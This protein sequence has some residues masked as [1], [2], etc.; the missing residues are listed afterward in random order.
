MSAPYREWVTRRG[1]GEGRSISVECALCPPGVPVMQYIYNSLLSHEPAP[2]GRAMEQ[3]TIMAEP[4]A[5]EG[6][7]QQKEEFFLFEWLG[8]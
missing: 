7:F 8:F 3:M 4:M 1:E 2:A 5:R 6:L